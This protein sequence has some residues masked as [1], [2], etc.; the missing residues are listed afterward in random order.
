MPRMTK[1]A[2]SQRIRTAS[3]T[4]ELCSSSAERTH[5]YKSHNSVDDVVQWQKWQKNIY[6]D[7]EAVDDVDLP[8]FPFLG[9]P[10]LLIRAHVPGKSW[11]RL[12][13]SPIPVYSWYHALGGVSCTSTFSST[14]DPFK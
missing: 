3:V 14:T 6:K 11:Q 10:P 4:A 2:W 13:D 7:D 12:T 1:D 9:K 5:K 8:A